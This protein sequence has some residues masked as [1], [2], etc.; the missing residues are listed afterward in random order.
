MQYKFIRLFY[1]IKSKVNIIHLPWSVKGNVVLFQV[2]SKYE[3]KTGH[4]NNFIIDP[5]Y[6]LSSFTDLYLEV[7][8]VQLMLLQYLL[9]TVLPKMHFSQTGM[10]RNR[11]IF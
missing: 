9:S 1:H 2:M 5:G 7:S 8:L 6:L 4:H 3:V 11:S 10:K